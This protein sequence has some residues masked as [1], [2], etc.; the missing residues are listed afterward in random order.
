MI[1]D[2]GEGLV[3]EQERLKS[4]I[5]RRTHERQRVRQ[6]EDHEVVVFARG[7]Q[8][9]PTVVDVVSDSRIR[10]GLERMKIGADLLDR[11]VNFHGIDVPGAVLQRHG[12]IVAGPSADDED[13]VVGLAGE[14]V[15]ELVVG[16]FLRLSGP[17]HLMRDAVNR[18]ARHW[19][20]GRVRALVQIDPVVRRPRCSP[21]LLQQREVEDANHSNAA[22]R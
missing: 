2:G 1:P 4:D 22:D 7:P 17:H 9:G 16:L 6:R 11:G 10:V 18:Y 13:L 19:N 5:A 14:P 8:K 3:G 12:H 21:T 15:V 20:A